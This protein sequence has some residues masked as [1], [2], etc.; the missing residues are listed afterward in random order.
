MRR[1]SSYAWAIAR[2]D[3]LRRDSYQCTQCGAMPTPRNRLEVHHVKHWQDGGGD[4]LG[5]LATLC[6][7][8]HISEHRPTSRPEQ[9]EWQSMVKEMAI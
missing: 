5:N 1:G 9:A 7:N 3:A 8:C 6:R 4:D 2:R